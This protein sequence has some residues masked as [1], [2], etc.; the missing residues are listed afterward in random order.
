MD[1]SWGLSGCFCGSGP[2]SGSADKHVSHLMGAC[3]T[4]CSVCV[5]ISPS[6]VCVCQGLGLNMG[7]YKDECEVCE[8]LYVCKRGWRCI[9]VHLRG[10]GGTL[11]WWL[12]A[13]LRLFATSALLRCCSQAVFHGDPGPALPR[14]TAQFFVGFLFLQETAPPAFLLL[15]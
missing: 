15:H 1:T 11:S 6:G 2:V 7:R 8:S 13:Q 9:A 10:G 3:L 5:F 12:S 4:G 14:E